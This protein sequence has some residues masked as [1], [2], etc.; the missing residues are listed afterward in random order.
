VV[1]GWLWQVEPVLI[2]KYYCYRF[3]FTGGITYSVQPMLKIGR[4]YDRAS[5]S[6]DL[7]LFWL[8]CVYS[9]TVEI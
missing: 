8:K 4:I 7:V 6:V 5:T 3:K 1:L 2:S 9:A